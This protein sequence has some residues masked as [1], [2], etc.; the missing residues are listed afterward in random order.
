MSRGHG[1]PGRVESSRET[2]DR[3]TVVAPSNI[4]FVKYWGARDLEAAVPMNRSISMTLRRCV[5]RCTLELRCPSVPDEIYLADEAGALKPAPD[6][7]AVP[8]L[9]HLEQLRRRAGGGV[10]FRVGARNSFPSSVGLASSASGFAALTLA[11]ARALEL[12]EDPGA[13]SGLAR[14]SGSGSAARSVFGGYVEWPGGE[15][16]DMEAPARRLA[17]SDHWDLRDV[18]AVVGTTPKE[19]SSR[20][21]HRRA[22]TSPH[23]AARLEAI[24]RRLASVRAA[25]RARDLEALG[26]VLE[27][28]A[29]ELHLVAM[30]SRPPVFYWSPA[31]LEVVDAV[32]GMREEGVGAYFTMDAG[33]NVHVL[34]L[35]GDEP[36]VASRLAGLA[37]VR[38]VIRDGVGE[39]PSVDAEHLL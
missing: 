35:P 30:S 34:C 12:E 38:R 11:A 21:G 8:V 37:P 29:I 20:E 4:A 25:V 2:G 5:S 33:P 15:G 32:R 17:T 18:I 39:G 27:E 23:Y 9:R 10:S 3:I 6:A 1:S 16:D 22:S 31:T 14:L 19:V 13:L 24:P 28:E 7:F 36:E 26:P